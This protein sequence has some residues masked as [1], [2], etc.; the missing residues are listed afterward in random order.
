MGETTRIRI[1][2]PGHEDGTLVASQ[3]CTIEVGGR[4]INELMR[5]KRLGLVFEPN[6]VPVLHVEAYAAEDV[7][8]VG[9]VRVH[10]EVEADPIDAMMRLLDAVDP[11]EW[12]SKALEQ[13]GLGDG[14]RTGQAFLDVL[15][16]WI[17]GAAT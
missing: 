14:K 1:T 5:V 6:E 3:A 15:K 8:V 17:G 4:N 2:S 12:E 9:V 7:D 13:M 10:H 16:G 11:E